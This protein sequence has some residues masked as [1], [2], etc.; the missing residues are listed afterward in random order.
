MI[1]TLTNRPTSEMSSSNMP[2]SL[3]AATTYFVFSAKNTQQS[4]IPGRN[5]SEGRR[6]IIGLPLP[7]KEAPFKHFALPR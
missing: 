5:G 3:I 2:L 1:T 4:E 7:Y 6:I